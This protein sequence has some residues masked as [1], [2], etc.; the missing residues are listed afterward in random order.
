MTRFALLLL[1]FSLVPLPPNPLRAQSAPAS[2]PLQIYVVDPEGGKAALWVTPAGQTVLLDAGSPG[3]RD[4]DRIMA[5]AADAGVSRIDYFVS[6]HYHSDHVGGL[7]ELAERIPIGTFVDHG[8]TVEGPMGGQLATFQDAYAALYGRAQHLV[9]KPGDRLPL[10]GLDW[11]VATSAGQVL[12]TP[13]AGAP[14]AGQPNPA[15]AATPAKEGADDENAASLGSVVSFGQFRVADFGDLLWKKEIELMCP[16]NPIGTVDVFMV[17]HH[18]LNASNPPAV[19]HGLRPRAAVMQNGTTKGAA[20]EV[21]ETLRSSPG[22]EDIWQ[23]HWS[24]TA[25]I[26][27][28]PPGLF[29]ANLEEPAVLG[30]RLSAPPP[31]PGARGRGGRRGAGPPPHTPAYWIKISAQ[32]DGSFTIGNSR[33]GFTKSYPATPR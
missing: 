30:A 21:M 14:G 10:T 27:H 20:V 13:I 9:V 28:N 25:G 22:L 26:E 33:N 12:E 1:V 23:I 4:V 29:V 17:T 19:V 2:R 31:A 24:Y 6:T 15:C 16:T 11:I 18:G 8:P 32:P 5:A 7:I 3:G